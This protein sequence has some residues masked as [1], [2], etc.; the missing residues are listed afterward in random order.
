MNRGVM[1]MK[2]VRRRFDWVVVIT[3]LVFAASCGGGGCG[4][5]STFESIPGGFPAAKRNPNAVQVRVS[6][7][8]LAAI[9]A[10]PAALIGAV[11]GGMNGVIQFNAPVNCSGSTPTCCPGGVP[12][13]VCGPINIDFN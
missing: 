10:D 12:Q 9:A 8:G 13:A 11:A 1:P 6:Q 2:R 4:G 7:S 3:A 5:C